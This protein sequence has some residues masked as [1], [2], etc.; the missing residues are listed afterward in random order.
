MSKRFYGEY[1]DALTGVIGPGKLAGNFMKYLENEAVLP[2][3]Q[4]MAIALIAPRPVYVATAAE[5]KEPQ[6]QGM[7]LALKYAEPVYKLLGTEGFEAE[8]MP[9]IDQP[10]MSTMGFHI[11]SGIHGIEE[12]DWKCFLDFADKFF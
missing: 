3:D 7:Y 2:F 1:S 10:V 8:Q 6:N 9:G 4:H 12:Y 5:Q 11:R